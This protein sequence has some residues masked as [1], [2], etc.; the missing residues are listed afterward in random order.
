[1]PAGVGQA[2]LAFNKQIVIGEIGS[3]VVA[4]AAAL[5][6]SRFTAD[7]ASISG[8]AVAGTLVGGTL[9]WIP[10]RISDQMAARRFSW[11]QMAGDIGYFTPAALV[12]GLLVYEPALYF[13]ARF[14]LGR[15]GAVERAVLPAQVLAFALFLAAMNLY[16]EALRRSGKRIL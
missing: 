11:R 3:L 5:A 1:M 12:L 7:A 2:A 15:G 14:L 16:R 13:T 6:A 8:F 9:A 10:A 4:N